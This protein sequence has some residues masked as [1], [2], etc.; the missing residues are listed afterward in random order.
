MSLGNTLNPRMSAASFGVW[1][2]AKE[3]KKCLHQSHQTVVGISSK[4][5]LLAASVLNESS[6]PE[7]PPEEVPFSRKPS[8][9][10]LLWWQLILFKLL[11]LPWCLP[12]YG[13]TWL[14]VAAIKFIMSYFFSFRKKKKILYL[15]FTL[16]YCFFFIICTHV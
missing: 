9:L 8:K 6:L 16:I 2:C 10:N 7:T 3:K 12:A 5:S 15:L 1:M 14:F 13:P 4:H 11:L